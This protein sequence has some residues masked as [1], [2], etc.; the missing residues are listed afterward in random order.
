MS[1]SITVFDYNEREEIIQALQSAVA[2]L[3][4]EF[5]ETEGSGQIALRQ[6]QGALKHFGGH[7][8]YRT[9]LG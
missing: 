5:W 4:V 9:K 8:R 2:V 6:C 7:I 3:S 1:D